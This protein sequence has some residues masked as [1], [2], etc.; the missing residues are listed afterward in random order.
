MAPKEE[1]SLEEVSQHASL[2]DCWLIINGKVYDVSK[3]MDEHPGGDE[4]LL[5]TTGKDAT[6]EFEDVGHSDTARAQM[7]TFLIGRLDDAGVKALADSSRKPAGG[8]KGGSSSGQGGAKSGASNSPGAGLRVLQLL[9]P[10][11][12]LALA[13]VVRHYTNKKD[14]A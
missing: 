6:L 3:F 12:I 5:S 8:A 14:I 7:D 2:T 11:L 1:Y 4:I 13:F 10:I 9:V